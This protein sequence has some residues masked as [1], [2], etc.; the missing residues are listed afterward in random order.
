M[1][2]GAGVILEAVIILN[3][4]DYTN[5]DILTVDSGNLDGTITADYVGKGVYSTFNGVNKESVY[6]I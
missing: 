4:Q 2:D 6:W 3:G 5:G 1:T